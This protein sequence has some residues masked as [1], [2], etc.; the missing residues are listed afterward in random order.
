[1]HG[2]EIFFFENYSL[3]GI[4]AREGCHPSGTLPKEGGE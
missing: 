4:T 3:G 2:G 1:M